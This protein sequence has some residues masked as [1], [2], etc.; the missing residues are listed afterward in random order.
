MLSYN[1]Q[2]PT[3]IIKKTSV[4][5]TLRAAKVSPQLIGHN[6]VCTSIFATSKA[7]ENIQSKQE[8]LLMGQ[9]SVLSVS[10]YIK[11]HEARQLCMMYRNKSE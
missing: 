11:K 2:G 7:A 6:A 3:G 10:Q 8:T 9:A 5:L 4:S 1:M